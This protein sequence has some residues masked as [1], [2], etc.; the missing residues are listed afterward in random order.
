M[1]VISLITSTKAVFDIAKGINALK[2]DVD[3][4]QAVSKILEALITVQT[5]ALSMQEKYSLLTAKIQE[6][7]KE[8]DRL[9]DW[10][11]EKERYELKEIA[12]GF[13]TRIEKGLVGN[14]QSAHKY[15]ANCF[16]HNFKALLQQEKIVEGRKLSLT[17]HRCKSKVLFDSYLKTSDQS[18]LKLD[19]DTD[20]ILRQFFD[21]S[22][23]LSV[24]DISPANRLR[25]GVVQYHFDILLKNQLIVQAT[26][27]EPIEYSLTPKG[28]A[29]VVENMNS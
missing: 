10:Q 27:H 12:H 2:N 29:Y 22:R 17:C 15:C 14:S 11:T 4:N 26:G 3:R 25:S 18:E 5:D 21:A 6:L 19:P 24:N 1:E 9:K 13:F 8:C 20:Q 28:R 16:D 23:D 7:E